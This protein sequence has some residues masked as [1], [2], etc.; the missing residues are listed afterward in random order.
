M[1]DSFVKDGGD[2]ANQDTNTSFQQQDPAATGEQGVD[3]KSPEYQIQMLQ[4]R[5][6]D[7]D[8]F[9]DTLK[10]ESQQAR[11]MYS[12]LEER[13]KNMEN[14][15]EVLKGREQDVNNQNTNLDESALVGKVIDNLNQRQTEEQYTSNYNSVLSRL[16]T[17]FGTEHIEGK[18]AEAA[19]ANGLSIN[20]MVET[21]RK[22]PKAFY[23][24]IG[25]KQGTQQVSSPAP[26]HG[27]QM[28]PQEEGTKDFA[29]Y[30][31]L[32][33]TN[34]KEYWKPETQREYRKLFLK[35]DTN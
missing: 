26:T 5:L 28:P 21:A 6:S 24:L 17:E 14:I 32:M 10:S 18:V 33:R 19:Q 1:T 20:D 2:N 15:S 8:E 7:K 11:E 3:T 35:Q 31:N 27:T 22:S 30:S 4:Q 29:Y 12:S 9:I 23:N 13:T 16:D 25:L 34:P